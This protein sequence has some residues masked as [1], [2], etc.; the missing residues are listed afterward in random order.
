M[1]VLRRRLMGGILYSYYIKSNIK[2]ADIYFDGEVVGVTSNSYYTNFKSTK[3]SGMIKLLGGILPST[4]TENEFTSSIL[5][6]PFVVGVSNKIFTTKIRSFQ[7]ITTYSMPSEK[8]ISPGVNDIAANET[9]ISYPKNFRLYKQIP[10]FYSLSLSEYD[11][12]YGE[13]ELTVRLS[14]NRPAMS[15]TLE[16]RGDLG[17]IVITVTLS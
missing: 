15:S 13:I 9:L 17:T 6:M 2:G 16:I 3:K 14:L 12:Y 10:L 7:H 11:T 5:N 4:K 8:I 1:S